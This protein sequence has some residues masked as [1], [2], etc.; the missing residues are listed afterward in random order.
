MRSPD[1]LPRDP[2]SLASVTSLGRVDEGLALMAG[3][4]FPS[5][6]GAKIGQPKVPVIGFSGDGAFGISVNEMTSCGREDWPAITMMVFRNYQWGAEK[7][8]T[9]LTVGCT[10]I[11][12]Y[13]YNDSFPGSHNLAVGP[14]GYNAK[15]AMALIAHAD[16]VL[17]LGTDPFSTLPGYGIDYRPSVLVSRRI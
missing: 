11:S 2:W 16:V 8:N 12:G 4:G 13:Q 1:R 6:L 15:A 17:A 5:I 3:Y 7:R 14:L 10:V 9:T